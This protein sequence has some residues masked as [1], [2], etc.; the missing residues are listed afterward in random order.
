M[1]AGGGYAFILVIV[2]PA[3]LSYVLYKS[4][5]NELV[6]DPLYRQRWG[7]MFDHYEI[8]CAPD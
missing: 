7:W 6:A 2:L 4:W 8:K 1:S 3:T 5:A